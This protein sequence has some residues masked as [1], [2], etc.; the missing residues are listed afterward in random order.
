MV[1]LT[2]QQGYRLKKIIIPFLFLFIISCSSSEPPA[3]IAKPVTPSKP[4]TVIPKPAPNPWVVKNYTDAAGAPSARKYARFDADGTFSNPTAS[5]N[6]LHSVFLL[7]KENAGILLS[8]YKKSGPAQKFSGQVTIKM[9]NSAGRVL[10]MTSSRGW[11]KAGG[12]M[13]EQNNNDYS[14][15]RIFMLQSAGTINVEILDDSASVYKFDLVATGFSD[16]LN[17]L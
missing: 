12:I 5:N 2:K 6:Y 7:N 16:S 17:Q 8:L 14:Q 13:I 1:L 3:D 9:K 4:K 10:E 11:N 15:F